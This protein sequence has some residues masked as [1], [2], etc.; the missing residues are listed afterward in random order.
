MCVENDACL[1]E[2][3]LSFSDF[4]GRFGL[5]Q[6]SDTKQQQQQRKMA[7]DTGSCMVQYFSVGMFE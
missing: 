7:L 2:S 6:S 1:S 4:K 5:W 3:I